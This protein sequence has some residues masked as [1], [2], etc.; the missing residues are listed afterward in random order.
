MNLWQHFDARERIGLDTSVLIYYLNHHERYFSTC[1]RLVR[2]IEF[3]RLRGVISAITEM[4]VLVHPLAERRSQVV[5]DIEQ[6]F[7][8]LRWLDIVPV[9]RAL[10]R[11]AASLRADTRLRGLDAIIATTALAAGCRYIVGN[12]R[13][14]ADRAKGVNYLVLADYVPAPAEGIEA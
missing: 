3:G 4:E 5:N 11:Q 2:E 7:R 14:F 8:R 1:Q 9:D 12:D 6:L 13:Q 10:A